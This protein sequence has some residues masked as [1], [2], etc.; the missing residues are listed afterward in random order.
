[1]LCFTLP[2]RSPGQWPARTSKD[3][4]AIKASPPTAGALTQG[5]SRSRRQEQPL[6]LPPCPAADTQRK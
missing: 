6:S 1:M 5:Q 4:G 3:L 2:S